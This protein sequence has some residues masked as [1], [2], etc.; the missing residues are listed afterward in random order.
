[1]ARRQGRTATLSRHK[2][3]S[4]NHRG[5]RLNVCRWEMK[6]APALDVLSQVRA[7]IP[8][9]T[10]GDAIHKVQEVIDVREQCILALHGACRNAA[11]R[12]VALRQDEGR[13]GMSGRHES[14]CSESDPCLCPSNGTHFLPDTEPQG[15]RLATTHQ[16]F[17]E[18]DQQ[19]CAVQKHCCCLHCPCHRFSRRTGNADLKSRE[20][21]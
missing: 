5:K 11:L 17:R 14:S 19:H 3:K 4:R 15:R 21:A 16:H 18:R 13:H 8:T 10:G 9:S 7:C 20:R 2:E 6:S 1:M 12:G